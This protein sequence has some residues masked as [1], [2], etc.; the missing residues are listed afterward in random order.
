M[1]EVVYVRRFYSD[2]PLRPYPS[3]EVRFQ[4]L[5]I[6]RATRPY[7]CVRCGRPISAGARHH[8]GNG[9]RDRLHL[10]CG[11]ITRLSPP[12]GKNPGKTGAS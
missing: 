3:V 8:I 10:T 9:G 4:R 5:T 11:K 2:R 7:V 1:S 12:W 6:W